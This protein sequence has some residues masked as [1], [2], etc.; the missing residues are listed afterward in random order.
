MIDGFISPY[1]RGVKKCAD[2]PQTFLAKTTAK[3]CGDCRVVR[4]DRNKAEISRRYRARM[5]H[6]Q[7]QK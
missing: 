7:I 4:M 1:E 6:E 2:C 5:R 3:Y